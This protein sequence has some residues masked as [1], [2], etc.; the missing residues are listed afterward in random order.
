MDG[1]G[2][3]GLVLWYHL[4]YAVSH[5][6]PGAFQEQVIALTLATVSASILLHGVTVT[7]FMV[8]WGEKAAPAI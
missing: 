3:R 5:G 8:R 1:L 4:V 2:S 6:L 7:P